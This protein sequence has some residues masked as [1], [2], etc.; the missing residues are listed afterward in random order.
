VHELVVRLQVLYLS[1]E[2]CSRIDPAGLSCFNMNTP[3][4]L[5]R[6]RKLEAGSSGRAVVA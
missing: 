5:A 1:E 2:H 4:D 3:A 6:A